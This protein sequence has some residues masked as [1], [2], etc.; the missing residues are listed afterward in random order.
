[1]HHYLKR[2]LVLR[3][4]AVVVGGLHTEGEAAG[5][6]IGIGGTGFV[7]GGPFVVESIEL[8]A[9]EILLGR[10]IA[11][12]R[13][14]EGDGIFIVREAD[15]IYLVQCLG[16]LIG[17]HLHALV[18]ERE[19]SD[20]HGRRYTVERNLLRT[21]GVEAL[22]SAEI[23]SAIGR[24]K[25]GIGKK[26]V[27]GQ[28]VETAELLHRLVLG[29]L[30]DA[31]A[32]RQ[33][34]TALGEEDGLEILTWG[35]DGDAAEG[36]AGRLIFTQSLKGGYEEAPLAVG[37]NAV[38][39]VAAQ[40]AGILLIVEILL[41]GVVA[42]KTPESVFLGSKPK[43]AL[44]ILL[45][46]NG[47]AVEE[48][49]S[50]ELL[51]LIIKQ[52][53]TQHG[54][55]PETVFPVA[56]EIVAAAAQDIAIHPDGRLR[57]RS[58]VHPDDAPAI[59]SHPQVVAIH[60]QRMGVVF[61]HLLL[62]WE[63]NETVGLRVVAVEA[64]I[65]GGYPDAMAGILGKAAHH[66]ALQSAQGREIH[67]KPVAHGR[68][69]D[70]VHTTIVGAYPETIF[71]IPHDAI[72]K[73][74]GGAA[75]RI[76]HLRQHAP[77]VGHPVI[78]HQSIIAA[79][80]HIAAVSIEL[81]DEVHAVARHRG[82]EE[83]GKA[84][85]AH[86]KESFLPGSHQNAAICICQHRHSPKLGSISL[87]GEKL[88]VVGRFL[89][90]EERSPCLEAER[91]H[92]AVDINEHAIYAAPARLHGIMVTV[93]AGKVEFEDSLGSGGN[94]CIM[95]PIN[96]NMVDEG[97][98]LFI[99]LLELLGSE[100]EEEDSLRGSHQETFVADGKCQDFLV[101]LHGGIVVGDYLVAVVA[102]ESVIGG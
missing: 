80:E 40:R 27:A 93:M 70:V 37:L 95:F 100:T 16:K 55:G 46:I 43:V 44:T 1:M 22:S 87:Q 24:Q 25:T 61:R 51:L 73:P 94:P 72:Y 90:A 60:E 92:M 15:F 17:T 19:R 66:A 62:A 65:V 41:P 82:N 78:L 38:Y 36:V 96:N 84:V 13:E 6:Q 58:H 79:N 89:K 26:L 59:G 20:C 32:R 67:V 48:F 83:F 31:L 9:V 47:K 35:I 30:H 85:V 45:H 52:E 34:H 18:E 88:E 10:D 102:A 99:E 12:C 42:T 71:P 53:G 49:Y 4:H 28:S 74:L 86:A 76:L 50:S 91:P 2:C 5:W 77:L 64:C 56:E 69:R 21:E 7:G 8:I 98:N 23:D 39:L 97:S 33:P 14:R 29:I 68:R 75:C 101:E 81:V 11:Q 54:C 3:P 63:I 57:P